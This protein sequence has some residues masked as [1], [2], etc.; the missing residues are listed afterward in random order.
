[1]KKAF[2]TGNLQPCIFYQYSW[3]CLSCLGL[4]LLLLLLNVQE[5]KVRENMYFDFNHFVIYYLS[6][7]A[8][9]LQISLSVEAVLFLKD[10]LEPI[11]VLFL[12]AD[13]GK[14]CPVCGGLNSSQSWAGGPTEAGEVRLC[15]CPI[16]LV[17]NWL[18]CK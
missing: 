7:Q 5:Q 14:F 18:L 15:G 2:I 11:S 3:Y 16:S 4:N 17:Q 13:I 8:R 6:Q 9:R 10:K 1:M 12:Q